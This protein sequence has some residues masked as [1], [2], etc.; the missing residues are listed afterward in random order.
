FAS[1][2]SSSGYAGIRTDDFYSIDFE[3]LAEIASEKAMLGKNPQEAKLEPYTVLLEE[4][5][6]GELLMFLAWIGFGART[7]QEGRS[8]M[9][10]KIGNLITGSNITIFDDVHH[11][12]MSGL[13]FDFEGVPK[14][15]VPLIESGVAKGVVYDS[16]YANKEDKQSTGHALLC[17]ESGPFPLNLVM[18]GGD[19]SKSELLSSISEGILITRFWYTRIVDPDQTQVT[20][21]TRDGTFLIKDGKIDQGLKNLRFTINILEAFKKV[22]EI[23]QERSMIGERFRCLAPSLLIEDFGF[24]G[25]TEY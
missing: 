6:V 11:P 20:G 7:F 5:A 23:S 12:Q 14:K 2:G 4:E 17:Q 18:E 16:F 1:S 25:K 24:T 10:G 13:V 21:M 19:A 22:R 8:F 15:R 3:E 9:A